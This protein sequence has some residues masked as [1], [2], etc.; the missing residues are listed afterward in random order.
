MGLTFLT[1]WLLAGVGLVAAPIILHLIMRKQPRLVVFPAL[2]FVKLRELANRRTLNLRHLL[3]LIARC[4]AILLLAVALARPSLQS[5]GFLGEQDAPVAAALVFDTSARMEY[6]QDNQTR[7]QA[8]QEIG[9][10]LLTQLP[11]ESGVAVL[12]TRTPGGDFAPD[13]LAAKQRVGVLK[14]Q[15]I[16]LPLVEQ[17]ATAFRLVTEQEAQDRKEVYLFTDLSRAAWPDSLTA[18]FAALR[19]EFNAV[20]LYIIDV[21]VTEPRDTS[22]GDVRLNQQILPPQGTLVVE[23][24]ANR[25]GADQEQEFVLYLIDDNGKPQKRG[26]L[27]KKLK[28][29]EGEP[30][31]FRVTQLPA[32]THQGVLQALGEDALPSNNQRYFTVEVRSARRILIVAPDRSENLAEGYAFY[33]RMALDPEPLRRAGLSRFETVLLRQDQLSRAD[34]KQ[35]DAVCLLD[36]E[37]LNPVIAEK[38]RD[39]VQTGGGLGIWLGHNAALEQFNSGA[40]RE[41]LPADLVQQWRAGD[42]SVFLAPTDL[43]HPILRP[44]QASETNNPWIDF[45]VRRFWQLGPL[46]PGATV[47]IPFSNRLPALLEKPLGQ[48]RIF[49]MT[50]PISESANDPNAW[51]TL[52]TGF[53]PWPFVILSNEM[54]L[55]LLGNQ[56]ER[57]NFF[58]GEEAILQIPEA[59]RALSFTLT[60]P[61]GDTLGQTVDQQTGLLRTSAT[62]Q[63][64]NYQLRAG[65]KRDGIQRGLS[66]NTPAA[67]FNLRRVTPTE[68]TEFLGEKRFKLART[69]E[70]IDRTVSTSRS[71]VELYPYLILLVALVLGLEYYLSNKFYRRVSDANPTKEALAGFNSRGE[72]AATTTTGEKS[73]PA[74]VAGNTGTGPQ[75]VSSTQSPPPPANSSALGSD[76]SGENWP[77][78]KG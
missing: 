55:Y 47:V 65:G 20:D 50:T 78:S 31:T 34:F 26:E 18:R 1:P 40:L 77:R 17:L 38:L 15:A 30:L 45:P 25:T 44:F 12:D 67:L 28:S 5:A 60:N 62:E 73:S 8:A 24:L 16:S 23:C 46:D 3:L 13:M 6:R 11:R 75:P 64:G 10:W 33:L 71:G 9:E 43:Q 37:P 70:E 72:S 68:L 53:D 63:V 22:L 57:F 76:L 27:T 49:V 7:L 54:T 48:G 19:Q 39:Y 2:R 69:R 51:N 14:P 52:A 42:R 35:Y 4:L 59:Q 74:S 58:A 29:D 36:P 32:G 21:G 56:S 66:V 61:V 41:L